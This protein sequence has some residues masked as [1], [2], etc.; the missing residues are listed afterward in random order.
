MQ[1]RR[2]AAIYNSFQHF[3]DIWKLKPEGGLGGTW[4]PSQVGHK[5]RDPCHALDPES[6]TQDPYGT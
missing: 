5:T 6:E 2:V 1:Q 4:D 3:W